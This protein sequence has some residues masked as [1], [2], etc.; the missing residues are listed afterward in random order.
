MISYRYSSAVIISYMSVALGGKKD[1]S[2]VNKTLATTTD[3]ESSPENNTKYY[4]C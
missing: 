4:Y 3:I 1:W 2:V